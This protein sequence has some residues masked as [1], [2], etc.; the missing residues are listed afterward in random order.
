MH[1][2]KF[3]FIYI[4]CSFMAYI[5]ELTFFVINALTIVKISKKGCLESWNKGLGPTSKCKGV[6]Q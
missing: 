6:I 1:R 3:C 5:V 4:S 2:Q